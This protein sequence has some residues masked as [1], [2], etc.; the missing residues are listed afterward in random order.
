MNK[1]KFYDSLFYI[2]L[3]FLTLTI[4]IIIIYMNSQKI[5]RMNGYYNAN[6]SK[7]SL[8][9]N[10]SIEQYSFFTKHFF[11]DHIERSTILE[12]LYNA[13]HTKDPIEKRYYKNLFFRALYPEY[14]KLKEDGIRQF[15]FILPDNTSY[16]RFHQL[17]KFGDDLSK[18]RPSVVYENEFLEPISIFETGRVISG[19]RNIYPLVYKNEHLGSASIGISTKAIIDTMK[20]LLP[21]NEFCFLLNKNLLE[22]KLFDSQ[23]FLYSISLINPNFLREDSNSVLPDSPQA[24]SLKAQKLAKLV[25]LEKNIQQLM[26][27]K[28][29]FAKVYKVDGEFYDIVL[30]PMLGINK[31]TEGYLVSF[32]KAQDIPPIVDFFP[33]FIALLFVGYF[34]TLI[35]LTLIRKKSKEVQEQKDWFLDV[36]NSLGEGMYVIDADTNI[37]YINPAACKILGYQKEELLGKSAHYLFHSHEENSNISLD[38]CPIVEAVK[39]NGFIE[40]IN[41]HFQ[42]KTGEKIP[43]ELNSRALLKEDELYQ[44]VTTFKDISNKKVTEEKMRLLTKAL[45][46]SANAIIITD[47]NANIEWANPAFEKLTGYKLNEI[48]GKK[49]KE[50]IKS[51][52]Q[53]ES[54]YQ[55]LWKTIL[56]KRSWSGEIIN[57]RKDGSLYYEELDITPVLNSDQN[58]KNF[59]AVKQD[60]SSRKE[61]E[62]VVEHLAYYDHL[63]NLPNR[64]LFHEHL[65]QLFASIQNSNNYAAILFLDLDKFKKLND[66]FGHDVGDILLRE[67]A[68]RLERNIRAKDIVARLGGDEFVVI[69]DNL[70]SNLLEAQ[71]ITKN[72][73]EKLLTILREPFSL[74]EL[75][76][77]T[78]VSIGINIFGKEETNLEE[79]LK[80]ADIALYEAKAKGRNTYH[81]YQ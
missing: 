70:G 48:L 55:D 75:I 26:N 54:F 73:A 39:R 29:V 27:K 23:K 28:K 40:S 61:R 76:Y 13:I 19:F 74:K 18:Y 3:I 34:I 50:F 9:Y 69:L 77:T 17:D 51:G 5:D 46:S 63:T 24:L 8:A 44:I 56:S 7:I 60:I 79:I 33:W 52:K 65:N 64:R 80:N 47:I 62:K 15:Q 57:K 67:V 14:I 22:A 49:P 66:T 38:K 41:E 4:S 12:N 81:F 37:V 53:S 21:Q 68:H 42:I 32:S 25:S 1:K 45:E 16:I 10:A 58:I 35:L 11:I 59:I 78:T 43:V 6:I 2:L 20:K 71:N 30:I 72:I 31:Q 36:N